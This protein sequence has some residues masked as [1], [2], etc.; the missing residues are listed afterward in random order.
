[1]IPQ[2]YS[3]KVATDVKTENDIVCLVKEEIGIVDDAEFGIKWGK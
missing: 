3:I 1:M 2:I